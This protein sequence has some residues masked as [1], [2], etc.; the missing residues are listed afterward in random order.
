MH[1]Y[2]ILVIASAL[3]LVL[4]GYAVSQSF[5]NVNLDSDVSV[6]LGNSYYVV[7]INA[8][9]GLHVAV[10]YFVLSAGTVDVYILD[11]EEYAVYRYSLT[12][13]QNLY[14][15]TNATLGTFGYTFSVGG[16][17]YIAFSHHQAY[18][19]SD[20]IVHVTVTASGTNLLYLGLGVGM[21]VLGVG[22]ATWASVE[23]R[24]SRRAPSGPRGGGALLYKPRTPR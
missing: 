6:P 17:Y 10:H 12:A 18:T 15:E 16:P 23:R 5:P 21:F 19:I 11:Q 9:P 14:N 13:N 1:A 7:R 4:S 2:H 8:F 22:L 3:V 24:V 20:Q